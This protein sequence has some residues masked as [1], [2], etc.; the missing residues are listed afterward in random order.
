MSITVIGVATNGY[1]KYIGG[2]LN[3]LECQTVKVDETIVVLGIN[4]GTPKKII[5]KI[6]HIIYI[7]DDLS[8]GELINKAINEVTSEYV[9]RVDIDDILLPNAIQDVTDIINNDNADAVSLKFL[10]SGR[11]KNSPVMDKN[12][13][14][15]WKKELNESGYVCNKVSCNGEK[16]YYDD[17]NFPN[18]PYLFK[19]A[20]CGFVFKATNSVCAV[21]QKR[22]RESSNILHDSQNIIKGSDV[23]T[24]AC[25]KY[26]YIMP[27]T[28]LTTTPKLK[29]NK[30]NIK[31][32][33][34]VAVYNTETLIMKCLNSI[35]L[36]KDIE[37]IIIDDCSSDNSVGKIQEWMRGNKGNIKLIQNKT[38]I[39]TGLTLNKGFDSFKGE[40]VMIL[41]DDDYLI[42]PISRFVKELDGS[43]LVYY[44]LV[45]N[46]G[47]VW[48][49]T[50]LPGS[51]KA[52]KRSIL[53][54]TRRSADRVGGDHN[55]YAEIL[56]KKPTT[57]NTKLQLY[58]YNYP[59]KNSLMDVEKR[60]DLN[61][62]VFTIIFNNYNE[63]L[64]RW[65]ECMQKQTL[66]PK[67]LI[68]VLGLNH[69]V[70]TTRYTN[71]RFIE[72][73]SKNMG[74]LRNKAIKAKRFKK[75]LYF[76]VD[77]ELLPNGIAQIKKKFKEFDVVGLK[78]LDRLTVGSKKDVNGVVT[79]LTVDTIRTSYT[80]DKDNF[81]KWDRNIVP[82]Y[83]AVNGTYEYDNIEVPNVPYLFTLAQ[84]GLKMAQTDEVVAIYHRRK[85]S[86]GDIAA[87]QGIRKKY[88][89]IIDEFEQKR[90]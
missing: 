64:D 53:G 10:R 8:L 29:S 68:V 67:E 80:V 69:G 86:H 66:V 40:Y 26:K 52:Y 14:H 50:I 42:E 16:I 46:T 78:F 63:F 81:T 35:K 47:K 33:I 32:S 4:H 22:K 88:A 43:D 72:C 56:T 1:G 62:T 73:D 71:V 44:D 58:H 77:D 18:I 87:K 24:N 30:T 5:R 2:W 90:M 9:L 15:R 34:I 61:I 12:K 55:F 23:I 20:N 60:I 48:D 3:F 84:A 54:D 37:V 38:N 7:E 74:E 41:C 6:K 25:E 28:I 51:T 89:E 31:L 17:N 21:Y 76:S 11:I 27:K 75:C 82:G 70:D 59:R 13:I 49:G 39:G 19:L 36:S 45:S 85:D 57:K 79:K 65:V 83:I